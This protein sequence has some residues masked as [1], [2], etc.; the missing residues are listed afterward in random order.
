MLCAQE[1]Y[2]QQM[3]YNPCAINRCEI[4][5]SVY[6]EFL[7]WDFSRTTG[8][9]ISSPLL[10]KTFQK[11]SN[12]EPGYRVGGTIRRACWG[13][14]ARYTSINSETSFTVN[15]FLQ[16]GD[17]YEHKSKWD[18]S[19]VD[20]L[21]SRLISCRWMKGSVTPYIGVKLAW[22]TKKIDTEF[23]FQNPKAINLKNDF[24]GYGLNF[25]S[26]AAFQLWNCCI[27]TS[28]VVD[29]SCALVKGSFKANADVIHA[30]TPNLDMTYN[31]ISTLLWVP[32]L[33]L[34]LAFDLFEC[35][36][37]DAQ[38][39]VGYETQLWT[40]YYFI[41][42]SGSAASPRQIGGLGLDGLVAR[43]TVGF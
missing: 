24:S 32:D 40:K 4:D 18:Y 9:R 26:R 8:E 1:S 12:Y 38:L 30:V 31:N 7:Y 41:E 43:L 10:D 34:G 27:P 2:P 20:I 5:F 3:E 25:G 28:L 22:I 6:G 39:S 42:E 23:F 36:C 11:K 29:L 16:P 15:N 14:E 17:R 37:F 33:Y 35:H 13:L 21:I 19:V